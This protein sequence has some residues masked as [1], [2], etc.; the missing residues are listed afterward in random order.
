M[1]ADVCD[2]KTGRAT[3]RRLHVSE[4]GLL[5]RSKSG[6]PNTL[7]QQVHERPY[8][9][10][11]RMEGRRWLINA[12]VQPHSTFWGPTVDIHLNWLL[13]LTFHDGDAYEWR[14]VP[15]RPLTR[16]HQA[17]PHLRHV[18]HLRLT[19]GAGLPWQ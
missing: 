6:L 12:E 10:A 1:R 8:A 11:M 17:R 9:G 5:R 4:Y 16:P 14:K 15:A 2:D 19:A 13:Q 18:C 3:I 7:Q